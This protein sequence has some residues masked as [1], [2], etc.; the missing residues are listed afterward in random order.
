MLKISQKVLEYYPAFATLEQLDRL[1]VASVIRR[2]PDVLY[3]GE[4]HAGDGDA[5]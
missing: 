4:R 5:G 3:E 2:R 1:N